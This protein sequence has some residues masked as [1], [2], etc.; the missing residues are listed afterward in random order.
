MT[1]ALNDK[2]IS[3][4]LTIHNTVPEISRMSHWLT[5]SLADNGLS[6]SIQF[7][8]DLC[9][10]EAV[11]NIISYAYPE[12]GTHKID[13]FLTINPDTVMLNIEDDGIAFNP[14]L[15]P[16]HSPSKSLADAKIGGLGIDLIRHY[17]DDFD[18]M[19]LDNKNVLSI[20]I[21]LNLG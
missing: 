5:D 15:V 6:K 13:L 9:A 3:R 16:E 2:S 4:S 14:L 1:K 17:V 19:R 12:N 8:F 7:R 18:Y 11:T 21:K 10:N 20:K